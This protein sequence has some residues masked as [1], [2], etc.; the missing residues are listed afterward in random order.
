MYVAIRREV[1]PKYPMQGGGR[2]DLGRGQ[3]R[4]SSGR[5][6]RMTYSRRRPRLESDA[7]ACRV[8]MEATRALGS[9]AAMV[10]PSQQDVNYDQPAMALGTLTAFYREACYESRTGRH[11]PLDFSDLAEYH[12]RL[13]VL[14]ALARSRTAAGFSPDSVI[15]L[16]LDA[17]LHAENRSSQ[18]DSVGA[19]LCRRNPLS[20][21]LRP[22]SVRLRAARVST[23]CRQPAISRDHA[24]TNPQ[25]RCTPRGPADLA[26]MR[27]NP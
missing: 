27:N 11:R 1:A 25:P 5:V 20:F 12:V 24:A 19:S 15:D 8:R 22:L 9:I 18:F 23:T 26:C 14:S 17:L 16:L 7:A 4:C 13:A 21:R 10:P 2:V 6:C 3:L